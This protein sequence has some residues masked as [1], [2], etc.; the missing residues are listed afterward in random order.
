[1]PRLP[2]K[3][4]G[5]SLKGAVAHGAIADFKRNKVVQDPDTEI[6]T[7]QQPL[8]YDASKVYL[9]MGTALQAANHAQKGLLHVARLID[10][11]QEVKELQEKA[12]AQRLANLVNE[13]D[14]LEKVLVK[15]ELGQT[16]QIAQSITAALETTRTSLGW[17]SKFLKNHSE[18]DAE[19][20]KPLAA[21]LA[22]I[23]GELMAVRKAKLDDT[24]KMED[25]YNQKKVGT[26][27]KANATRPVIRR[28]LPYP[29]APTPSVQVPVAE[30]M[31][32]IKEIVQKEQSELKKR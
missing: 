16:R 30:A 23:V 6:V 20:F 29:A 19:A 11:A 15:F 13:I 2:F 22:A 3:L 4:S 26:T 14:D 27:R 21:R 32:A 8:K 1:M 28:N 24:V 12:I 25:A 10:T 9:H 7:D 5:S 17:Y 31:Q 18:E